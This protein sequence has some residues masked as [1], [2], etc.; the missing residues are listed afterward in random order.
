[1]E[2]NLEIKLTKSVDG[3]LEGEK[4]VISRDL[5]CEN[6]IELRFGE[7]STTMTEKDFLDYFGAFRR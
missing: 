7:Y 1:M 5:A 6:L 3:E 2:L 4:L